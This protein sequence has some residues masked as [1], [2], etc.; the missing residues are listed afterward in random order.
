MSRGSRLRPDGAVVM[1]PHHL[2]FYGDVAA[3]DLVVITQPKRRSWPG[4][5]IPTIVVQA[6]AMFTSTQTL[7]A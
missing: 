2:Y 6:S 5:I 7:R 1:R 3:I 4:K